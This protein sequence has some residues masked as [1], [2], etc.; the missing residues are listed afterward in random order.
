[1]KLGRFCLRVA[2]CKLVISRIF[3]ANTSHI[4][5]YSFKYH[6]S[7]VFFLLRP[8]RGHFTKDLILLFFKQPVNLNGGPCK[9]SKNEHIQY[10]IYS[11]YTTS[12]QPQFR[13]FKTTLNF[14]VKKITIM[15]SDLVNFRIS[16]SWMLFN[17]FDRNWTTKY[18]LYRPG[19][20]N[21][22]S[23]STMRVSIGLPRSVYCIV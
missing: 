22:D 6:I 14:Q 17:F 2:Y 19:Q 18:Q 10:Q 12:C 16:L 15:L 5:S 13:L 4:C 23:Y 8:L 1:M 21:R 11:K 7:I 9:Y 3:E 20:P